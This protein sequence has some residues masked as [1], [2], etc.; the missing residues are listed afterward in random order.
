MRRIVFYSWQSDSPNA[1]NRGFIQAALEA[2]AAAITVDDT[3]SVEPV[4]DRDTQDV[5]G[6]PDIASTIFAKIA[7][8]DIFVADV[9]ITTRGKGKRP[10]PNPN[11]LV[12]LGYALRALGS[13]RVI[14]IFNRAFGKP[15]ELPFDLRAR[16]VLSYSMAENSVERAPE[17]KLLQA[18]LDRTIRAAFATS[19]R[20]V[21][22]ETS[23]PAVAA[24]EQVQPNRLVILRRTLFD[25]LQRLEKLEP[26]K[27]RDD[28]TADELIDALGKTQEAIAEFSRIAEATAL[29]KDEEASI[30]LV[31][32]FGKVFEKY[33][34]PQNY[35]GPFSEADHDYFKFL[36][37]EMF[38]TL[39]AFLMKERRWDILRRVLDE[40]IPMA[41]LPR[42]DSG[43]VTWNYASEHLPLLIEEGSKRQRISLHG[44]LLRDRH[45][46]GG[47][48]A[49]VLP[50]EEL[51]AADFF[52]F[53]LS[54][55]TSDA[56]GWGRRTWRAWSC[57]NLRRTPSFIQ[58][59][60]RTRVAEQIS[61]LLGLATIEEFKEL[62]SER[63][64]TLGKLFSRGWW[65]YPIRQDEIDQI[66]T[67]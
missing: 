23:I 26:R 46:S 58:D 56:S 37:H 28:G 32:W 8:A 48:L 3:V 11:V 51:M 63:G 47:G 61:N 62:L 38:V 15:E 43:N 39:I 36:G 2:A 1:C 52:L 50:I 20:E 31:R 34:L 40:P 5:P 29:M 19:L 18:Q 24:I 53:L 22:N 42:S 59:S 7:A 25:I 64:P 44:D 60:V 35:S 4:I 45:T 33:N 6:A 66:G 14:L 10:C 30:E 12:E 57:L 27:R 67:Q 9:S 13:E 41:F 54:Q 55:R 17:K 65:D 21:D 16:R 49:T